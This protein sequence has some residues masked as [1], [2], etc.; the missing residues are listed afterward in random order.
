M[1]KDLGY[2]GGSTSISQNLDYD[3]YPPKLSEAT[4]LGIINAI[5]LSYPQILSCCERD[6]KAI[7]RWLINRHLQKYS[8]TYCD[9][10]SRIERLIPQ[11]VIFYILYGVRDSYC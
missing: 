10:L 8:S 5:A 9:Y 11:I 3:G 1:S 7:M 2:Y 6:K 4:R